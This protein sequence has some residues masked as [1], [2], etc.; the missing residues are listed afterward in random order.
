MLKFSFYWILLGIASSVGLGTGLHTFV[1][2]LGPW[3]AKF[4]IAANECGVIPTM[5]PNKWDFSHFAPCP[6]SSNP[7][8][9]GI[10]SIFI[11]VAFEGFLWGLGTAIG[12]LPPSTIS[13]FGILYS[14]YSMF[15]W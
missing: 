2:Y 3:M 4:T 11:N 8:E 10:S 13:R 1:L 14:Y 6:K 7:T 15:G 5:L 12:E 9:V